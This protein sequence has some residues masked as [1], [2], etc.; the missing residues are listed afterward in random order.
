MSRYPKTVTIPRSELVD[1]VLDTGY[2]I[3]MKKPEEALECLKRFQEEY[4]FKK[5][6]KLFE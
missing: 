1:L 4:I 5:Q 6:L 2:Y 3:K